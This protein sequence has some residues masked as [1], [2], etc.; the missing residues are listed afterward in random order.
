MIA[1]CILFCLAQ[2]P[3][4]DIAAGSQGRAPCCDLEAV[5]VVRSASS[6]LLHRLL[7]VYRTWFIECYSYLS[8]DSIAIHL[9][10]QRSV[11]S[12]HICS[13]VRRMNGTV[14]CRS[15]AVP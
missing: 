6:C 4:L 13:P 7:H 3:V 11:W 15:V 9:L 12:W 14:R 1:F 5:R 2:L 10:P 8:V